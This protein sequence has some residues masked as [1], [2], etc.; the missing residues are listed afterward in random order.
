MMQETTLGDELP[1][2]W[3]VAYTRPRQEARAQENLQNQ[4]FDCLLPTLAA[5]RLR[6]GNWRSKGWHDRQSD[7]NRGIGY[8]ACTGCSRTRS[9]RQKIPRNWRGM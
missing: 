5:D 1:S 9:D 3:Y 8:T 2:G 6:G 4:G 7:Q